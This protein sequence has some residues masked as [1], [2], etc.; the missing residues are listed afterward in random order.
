MSTQVS[1]VREQLFYLKRRFRPNQRLAG[2]LLDSAPWIDVVLLV[3]LF[4]ITQTATLKKPGLRVDLPQ[5]RATGGARYDAQ[6]L[7]VPQE[8]TY[9]FADERIPWPALAERLRTAAAAHAGG[10]LIIEADGSVSHRALTGIYN[11]A[12]DAGWHHVVI[13]TRIDAST[14]PR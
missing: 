13:A 12:V 6:V 11:L 8:G 14:S 1:I 10:E 7:T 5:A 4:M 9:F 3:I 2:G